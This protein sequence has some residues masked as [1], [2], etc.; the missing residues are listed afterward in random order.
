MKHSDVVYKFGGRDGADEEKEEV[1][2]EVV[3][4]FKQETAYEVSA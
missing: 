3:F 2:F 4:F 1:E